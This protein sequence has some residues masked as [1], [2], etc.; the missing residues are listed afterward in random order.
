ML[1]TIII[2]P[3]HKCNAD[4]SYC[5]V[6]NH[7]TSFKMTFEDFKRYFDNLIPVLHDRATFIWHGG[8]PMILGTDFYYKCHEYA[9]KSKPDI[10]FSM[11]SN[12]LL[13]NKDWKELILKVMNGGVS[14][15]Y[16]PDEKSRTIGGNTKKYHEVFFNKLEQLVN[17]NLSTVVIAT[18][19][20]ETIPYAH[21]MYE[22]AN[23]YSQ[24]AKSFGI[25]LNYRDPEGRMKNKGV[26][27]QPELYGQMLI[28]IYNRWIKEVPNFKII[29]MSQLLSKVLGHE[30]NRCPWTASCA[31]SFI[32]LEPNGD[33]YNCASFSDIEREEFCFGNLNSASIQEILNS[34]PAIK[35]QRRV[36]K[37]PDECIACP[38]FQE[39]RGGCMKESVL[40]SDNLYGKTYYCKA[41]YNI[42]ERIKETV[43]SGEAAPIIEK[44]YDNSYSL[45]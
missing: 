28:D 14:T 17:D 44:F 38:H 35:L 11:Q 12:I 43:K 29:P 18:F 26:M 20:E 5:C 30:E 25:R 7:D 22:F 2:K 34:G 8:E 39:C 16:D 32:G 24:N 9:I 42:L 36:H 45:K 13:Y 10:Q 21:K 19:G 27:V 6:A 23:H 33:V 3:T 31:R 1:N 37:L 40:F 41:W 4:C 15:S